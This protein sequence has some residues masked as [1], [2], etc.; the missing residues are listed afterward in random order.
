MS[1]EPGEVFP[2]RQ[3]PFYETAEYLRRQEN[4]I[5]FEALA[6]DAGPSKHA[7][8]A[9]GNRNLYF[10]TDN[11]EYMWTALEHY[12]DALT[13]LPTDDALTSWVLCNRLNLFIHEYRHGRYERERL[14]TDVDS[15]EEI[16][17]R[18]PWRE[19]RRREADLWW[20]TATRRSI[21]NDHVLEK[22]VYGQELAR[23]RNLAL[24]GRTA[25]E[26]ATDWPGAANLGPQAH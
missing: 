4:D 14:L 8:Y 18:I 12:A 22:D 5:I 25:V 9:N 10:Q 17:R 2:D 19:R 21:L 7:R 20:L 6:D 13:A 23:A 15:A 11:P 24:V 26:S 3:P 1:I 16:A